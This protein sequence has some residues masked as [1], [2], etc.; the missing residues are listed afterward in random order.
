MAET[1]DERDFLDENGNDLRYG[2]Y[3][4]DQWLPD[5]PPVVK[6]KKSG[7]WYRMMEIHRRWVIES[8]LP[9]HESMA[10]VYE[11]S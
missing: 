1:K 3:F 10:D 6:L 4:G 9:L 5:P 2:H 7:D 11:K 8:C